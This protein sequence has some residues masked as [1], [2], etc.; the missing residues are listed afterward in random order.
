ML[1]SVIKPNYLITTPNNQL[2]MCEIDK[3]YCIALLGKLTSSELLEVAQECNDML[4][5]VDCKE[6]AYANAIPI[7]TVQYRVS[8]NL[9]DSIEIS[10]RKYPC[11][12]VF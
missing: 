5:V 9:I 12:N 7:R 3:D 10:G 4:A 1:R 6:Y 11:V 2:T 8:K